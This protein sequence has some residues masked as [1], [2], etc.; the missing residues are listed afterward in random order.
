MKI[1]ETN[2]PEVV[3][4]EPKLFK[5]SRG[6]FFESYQVE[7]YD[8]IIN[9]AKFVQDNF[10]RSSQNVLR[11]LHYQLQKP[12]GKLVWVVSG[13]AFDVAVDIRQGSPTFGQH[14]TAILDGETHRQMYIPPGFA[15]GFCVLSPEVNF[16]YK[17]TDYYDPAGERG[18]RWDDPQLNIDWPID[19]PLLSDKDLT[20]PNLADAP[21]DDLPIYN[22]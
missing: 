2:I 8:E 12:Q 11:G 4:I 5:D 20:Y 1:I 6:Y 15:H 14:V 19:K 17:C 9:S 10:S 22:A 18:L 3:I 13:K 21:E 7:K 16:C